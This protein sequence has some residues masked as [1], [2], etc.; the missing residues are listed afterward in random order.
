M[1]SRGK[2]RFS[3]HLLKEAFLEFY[4]KQRLYPT[5]MT[6]SMECVETWALRNG[7]A[8]Q[9][10]VSSILLMFAFF[11]VPIYICTSCFILKYF[12]PFPY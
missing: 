5:G 11:T 9:R 12:I 3:S 6:S 4:E 8:M 10:L 1:V 2:G 7:L